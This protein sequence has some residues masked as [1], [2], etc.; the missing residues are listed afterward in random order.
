MKAKIALSALLFGLLS[1]AALAIESRHDLVLFGSVT[2]SAGQTNVVETSV[3]VTGIARGAIIYQSGAGATTTTVASVRG[4][5]ARTVAT[6][7]TDN[8]TVQSNVTHNLYAELIRFTIVNAS[9]NEVTITPA[10]IY[11]K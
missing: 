11:E 5:D 4:S 10:I 6:I 3:K 8:T 1:A 7:A 2:V 9:T